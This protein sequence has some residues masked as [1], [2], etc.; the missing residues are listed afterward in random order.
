MKKR[1]FKSMMELA[2]AAGVHVDT[3]YK[4][5]RVGYC[6]LKLSEK[7]SK[8]TGVP[9]IYWYNHKSVKHPWHKIGIDE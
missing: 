3:L 7:L 4:A 1:K 8:A 9:V 5:R 2:S 6:S